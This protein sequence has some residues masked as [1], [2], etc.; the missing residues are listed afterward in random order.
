MGKYKISGVPIVDEKGKLEGTVNTTRS[1]KYEF[2]QRI[3]INDSLKL[4]KCHYKR[5]GYGFVG[6]RLRFF[7]LKGDKQK[8]TWL[9][10]CKDGSWKP[11][12]E[13]EAVDARLFKDEETIPTDILPVGLSVVFQAVWK[14]HKGLKKLISA[15]LNK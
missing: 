10:Y 15:F 12:S 1:G 9:W 7:I 13:K 3:F 14:E 6:W 2:A 8:K 11:Y 5:V 4:Q